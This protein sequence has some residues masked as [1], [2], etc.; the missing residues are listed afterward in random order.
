MTDTLTNYDEWLKDEDELKEDHVP[1]AALVMRQRLK[2]V[3]EVAFSGEEKPVI[4]P[5]TYPID[6]N[7]AGYNIDRFDDGSSV[8]Q[9]DSVGSQA[10]R[11]EPIFKRK[12]YKRLVPQITINAKVTTNSQERIVPIHL[13]D[14]GHRAADSIARFSTLGPEL[15]EA[16]RAFRQDGNAEKLARVAPASIV[17]GSWDSR[18]TQAKLPRIVRSVIRA[19]DVDELHRSAQYSTIAGEI[20]EGGDAEVTTKGVK[21][22]LGLA[23]V[24]SVMTHGGVRVN[25]EIRREAVLNLVPLRALR[26]E[27]GKPEENIKLRRYILGLALVAIT[28]PQESFLREGCQLVP[29]DGSNPEWKVVKHDGTRGDF[30]IT[31]ED[32]LAFATAAAEVFDV[33]QPDRPAEFDADLAN[34]VQALGEEMRKK[35][36]RQGPVTKEAVARLTSGNGSS[37]SKMKKDE[38]K[39]EC[40][41][42]GLPTDGTKEDL[43]NRL[44]KSD[45]G[46]PKNGASDRGAES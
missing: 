17:F 29:A 1:V 33:K 39:G 20:L 45:A 36:L 25:G 42:R 31:H 41:N 19:F 15:H 14:A 24:P 3:E 10:N 40:E 28:A 23:H 37:W 2:P 5:P 38:L 32:A 43:I 34:K 16:F 44:E 30:N 8:C 12:K 7:K 21:A 46:D 22:E 18:A 6:Q 27:S 4:F 11:M 9:I 13:L 26:S 35:V